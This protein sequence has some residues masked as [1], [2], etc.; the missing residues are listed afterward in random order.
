M[1]MVHAVEMVPITWKR[2]RGWHSFQFFYLFFKLNFFGIK[3]NCLRD[4]VNSV[5]FF[6]SPSFSSSFR[7]GKRNETNIHNSCYIDYHSFFLL[8][9]HFNDQFERQLNC[10]APKQPAGQCF[11]SIEQLV[12]R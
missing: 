5:F 6:S 9:H 10:F 1:A 8:D 3:N 11:R 12:Y 2:T 7:I 4:D